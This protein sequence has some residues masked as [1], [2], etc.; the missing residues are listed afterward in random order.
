MLLYNC[1]RGHR[2]EKK[3]AAGSIG[4]RVLAMRTFDAARGRSLSGDARLRIVT[5]DL[6]V[7]GLSVVR[8]DKPLV[9]KETVIDTH[10]LYDQEPPS[11]DLNT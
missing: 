5:R 1:S 11:Y 8:S 7:I 10:T 3:W 6:K 2:E 4:S 9:E